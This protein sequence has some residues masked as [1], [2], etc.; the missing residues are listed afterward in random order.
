MPRPLPIAK[1]SLIQKDEPTVP[2]LHS[3]IAETILQTEGR[4]YAIAIDAGSQD[5]I[6]VTR[7]NLKLAIARALATEF[8]HGAQ[9]QQ[10]NGHRVRT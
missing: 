1:L 6:A 3:D 10:R 7:D 5:D 8:A 9:Q 2:A 4:A